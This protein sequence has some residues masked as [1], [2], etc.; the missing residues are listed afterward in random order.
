[1]RRFALSSS[2]FWSINWEFISLSLSALSSL[3]LISFVCFATSCFVMPSISLVSPS[4]LSVAFAL[5]TDSYLF[6]S[7]KGEHAL[8]RKIVRERWELPLARRGSS[9]RKQ[10]W[11]NG[12]LSQHS[13]AAKSCNL[14]RSTRMRWHTV[15]QLWL[16]P[17]WI[18]FSIFTTLR[19]FSTFTSKFS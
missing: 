11:R 1:M 12:I 2:V 14:W 18:P 19:H 10:W 4:A 8:F 6:Q 13:F 5:S 17:W 3:D 9:S 15:L 7:L 16:P